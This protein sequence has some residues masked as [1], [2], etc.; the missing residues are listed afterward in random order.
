MSPI[1]IAGQVVVLLSVFFGWFRG[2]RTER[3]G[4]GVLLFDYMLSGTFTFAGING[5]ETVELVSESAV[6]LAFFWLAL[7]S[8][9]WWP[10][11]V[12]SSMV[13]IGMVLFLERVTQDLSL[14][15][16]E[17]A[18]LGLWIIIWSAPLAGVGERWLAGERALSDTVVWRRR[19]AA[20]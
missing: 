10:V 15:A 8:D 6:A 18:Q 2:G 3:L 4:V 5:A 19:R 17:S 9:R 14:Y 7:R 1:F 16:S 11:I 20:P 12:G 13:L